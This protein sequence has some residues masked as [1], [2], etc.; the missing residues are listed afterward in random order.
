LRLARSERRR[1]FCQTEIDTLRLRIAATRDYF[2]ECDR[3]REAS[4]MIGLDA[5]LAAVRQT[6]KERV[7]EI[8]AE[9][10]ATLDGFALQAW[11]IDMGDVMLVEARDLCSALAALA[12]MAA[13]RS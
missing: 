9:R 5:R 3:Q 2:A 7:A 4:G 12:P 13:V 10:A 8:L 1:A 6:I 11:A